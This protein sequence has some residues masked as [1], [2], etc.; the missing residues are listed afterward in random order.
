MGLCL[1]ASSDNSYFTTLGDYLASVIGSGFLT[2]DSF[3]VF[4]NKKLYI[5]LPKVVR[6]D[7]FNLDY[8]PVWERLYIGVL[9]IEEQA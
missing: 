1:Q 3:R 9:S 8:G 6:D 4:T 5:P 2:S 7:L